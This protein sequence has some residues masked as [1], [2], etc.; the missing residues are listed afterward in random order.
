MKTPLRILHLED[1]P[2][3]VELIR[4]TIIAQGIEVEIVDAATRADFVAALEKGTYAPVLADYTLPSFDGLSALK[5]CKEKYP[6][7]PFIFVTG[8]VEDSSASE[9]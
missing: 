2:N 1:N 9:M 8:T 5:I 6:D 7:I 4:E 3:D